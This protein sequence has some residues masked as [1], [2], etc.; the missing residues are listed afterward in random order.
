MM[1]A[2]ALAML[3]VLPLLAAGQAMYKW[4]DERGVTHFSDDP[5]P[6]GKGATKMEVKPA[7]PEGARSDDW[8]ERELESRRRKAAQDMAEGDQRRKDEAQRAQRCR[9]AQEG[10]DTVKNSRRV[11]T[12]DD[13]GER[14]YM[15]DSERP[16]A[17]ARWSAEVEAN[18]R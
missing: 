9:R 1:R 8:R 5:P 15:G 6:D 16:A 7:A 17:I 12:L 18:C 13:K 11:Y 2:V 10:L 4:V 3:L 14:V